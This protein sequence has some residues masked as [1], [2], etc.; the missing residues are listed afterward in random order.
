MQSVQG[1]IS[2]LEGLFA[3]LCENAR[4]DLKNKSVSLQQLQKSLAHNSKVLKNILYNRECEFFAFIKQNW[5]WLNYELLGMVVNAHCSDELKGEMKE[6]ADK[7]NKFR[8]EVTVDEIIE[9]FNGLQEPPSEFSVLRV[10]MDYDPQACTLDRVCDICQQLCVLTKLPFGPEFL[11][12]QKCEMEANSLY[13]VW[14]MPKGFRIPFRRAIYQLDIDVLRKH[15]LL[16]LTVDEVVLYPVGAKSSVPGIA[17]PF[18]RKVKLETVGIAVFLLYMHTFTHTHTHTHKTTDGE[19]F[20]I[21]LANLGNELRG[22]DN[23]ILQSMFGHGAGETTYEILLS[24][25][26]EKFFS[27]D[28]MLPLEDLLMSLNRN[29]LFKECLIPFKHKTKPRMTTTLGK[30]IIILTYITGCLNV[31]GIHDAVISSHD[32]CVSDDGDSDAGTKKQLENQH[33]LE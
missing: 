11:P 24:L 17:E 8:H 14:F 25:E 3:R 10:K 23:L 32:S 15:R 9:Y 27:V 20:Q 1:K 2:E 7:V 26:K 18:P 4:V 5:S 6:Y 21:L 28:N 16:K 29:D 30:T 19:D 13:A 33:T 31:F 22:E 12:F